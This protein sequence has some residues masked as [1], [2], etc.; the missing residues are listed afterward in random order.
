MNGIYSIN[1]EIAFIA[2]KKNLLDHQT[3]L[4]P[5]NGAMSPA[6]SS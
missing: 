5:T 4:T 2:E 1:F 3:F 6:G